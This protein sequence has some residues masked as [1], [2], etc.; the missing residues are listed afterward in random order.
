MQIAPPL[1]NSLKKSLTKMHL[2]REKIFANN[3]SF[4]YDKE[5]LELSGLMG[6][7]E[8]IIQISEK[9]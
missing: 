6:L 8:A 3:D 2:L 5:L 7:M 4:K 9:K 1:I